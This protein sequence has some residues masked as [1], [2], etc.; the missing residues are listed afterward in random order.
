VLV[1]SPDVGTL[2]GLIDAGGGKATAGGV[3]DGQ[4]PAL[5]VAGME[6]PRIGEIAA[7]H[8]IVLHELTP[9]LP[10]LEEAFLELTAGSVEYTGNTLAAQQEV[11]AGAT[12]PGS[13]Q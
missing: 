12:A 5:I 2:A 11:A 6:A 1:R 8:G 13:S 7:A 3:A 9:Q 10:S 4:A